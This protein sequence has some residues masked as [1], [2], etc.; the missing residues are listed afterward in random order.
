MIP[1]VIEGAS[2]PLKGAPPLA[3]AHFH[4]AGVVTLA[5]RAIG[6]NPSVGN[7]YPR[8]GV[9]RAGIAYERKVKQW[10]KE[11]RPNV[12]LG[13]WFTFRSGL[14]S[15]ARYC[16]PDAIEMVDGS[17]YIYE[18]KLRYSVDAWWQIMRLYHP[19]LA[20]ALRPTHIFSTI[21]CRVFDPTVVTPDP[22]PDY[23][24]VDV[25]PTVPPGTSSPSP[26]MALVW[27]P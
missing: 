2:G 8:K 27:R 17:L 21:I 22:Q 3:P 6:W 15:Q 26:L 24:H 14:N 7:R 20:A 25:L 23:D 5:R 18:I 1:L 11:Q 10:L 12:E 4:P 13:P 16:Q 9:Y 19:V